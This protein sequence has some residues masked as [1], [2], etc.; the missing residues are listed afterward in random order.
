MLVPHNPPLCRR[1]SPASC[2]GACDLSPRARR[3]H[4]L[5]QGVAVAAFAAPP[6]RTNRSRGVGGSRLFQPDSRCRLR[7]NRPAAGGTA[8]VDG[9]L[10]GRSDGDNIQRH[11]RRPPP[12]VAP[13]GFPRGAPQASLE[14]AHAWCHSGSGDLRKL[15]GAGGHIR[16]GQ[17][18]VLEIAC[19]PGQSRLP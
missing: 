16:F 3:R 15:V 19:L 10:W 18:A 11:A 1:S 7:T 2:A 5:L 13:R 17:N 8:G 4:D 14:S 6:T 12:A 9:N